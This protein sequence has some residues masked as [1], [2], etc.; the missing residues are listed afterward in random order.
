MAENNTVMTSRGPRCH[1]S[2]LLAELERRPWQ[3][4]GEVSRAAGIDVR[5]AAA[6]LG[7]LVGTSV[8][9]RRYVPPKRR[10]TWLYAPIGRR[11]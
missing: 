11:S 2:A 1:D 3:T 4:S 8:R 10:W 7:Q 6:R 5:A 9:R